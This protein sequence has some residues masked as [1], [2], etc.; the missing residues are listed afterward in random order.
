MKTSVF[1]GP[2]EVLLQL[3][4]RRHVEITEVILADLISDYLLGLEGSQ[5]DVD[6]AS[7][8][9]LITATL[10]QLKVR[11]LLPDAPA[12]ALDEELALMEERD[13]LLGRLLACA[14]FKDVAA[15]LAHRLD[16]CARF[17]PRRVGMDPEVE[18]PRREVDLRLGPTGLRDLALRML[19]RTAQEPDLDH[20]ELDLPSVEEA[21]SDL[22]R[23][24]EEARQAGFDQLTAHCRN[25]MEV[26]AYF[27]AMLELARW[28]SV[29]LSQPEGRPEILLRS[30]TGGWER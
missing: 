22:R 17:V 12:D 30:R 11:R 26:V 3:T 27:L 14:T 25:R 8:F 1:E 28:G 13:R 5:L 29:E 10:I 21:M 19:E 15:L 18:L 20:L 4:S 16:G 2:L 6:L 7:E 9:L 24:L 23:R